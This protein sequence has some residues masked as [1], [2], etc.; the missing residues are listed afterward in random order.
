MKQDPNPT[1]Y[2]HLET[3]SDW[4]YAHVD[5]LPSDPETLKARVQHWHPAE[6][7]AKMRADVDTLINKRRVDFEKMW[8]S[9]QEN[10]NKMESR[11]QRLEKSLIECRDILCALNTSDGATRLPYM[12]AND[13]PSAIKK[14]YEALT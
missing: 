13:I 2:P 8:R 9:T 11:A 12:L 7:N 5:E 1:D 6:R 4:L 3:F 10:F 14:G